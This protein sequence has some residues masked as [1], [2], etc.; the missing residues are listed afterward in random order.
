MGVSE[1]SGTP[2]S[3]ILIGFSQ[4]TIHFGVPLFLETPIFPLEFWSCKI[5]TEAHA[6]SASSMQS[7]VK[8][9]GEERPET[10][11][12]SHIQTYMLCNLYT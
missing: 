4:K 12:F 6:N 9:H 10:H 3:S 7:F 11:W 1:N 2:K 5:D 8:V